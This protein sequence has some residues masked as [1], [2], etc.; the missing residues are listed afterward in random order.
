M[1]DIRHVMTHDF[2]QRKYP[3]HPPPVRR[4]N[5]PIILLVTV[6]TQDRAAILAN[7]RVH[8]ALVSAWSQATHWLVGYYWPYTGRLN[9]LRW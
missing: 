6:C 4:H 7:E 1:A 9:E 8:D 2:P 5:Q 3:A